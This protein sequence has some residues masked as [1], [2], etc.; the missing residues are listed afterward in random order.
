MK[1]H[2]QLGRRIFRIGLVVVLIGTLAGCNWFANFREEKKGIQLDRLRT[3]AGYKT[4]VLTADI[5]K[6]RQM[7]L[8]NRGTLFV[9]S[10]AG[11]VHAL[12]L[13]ANRVVQARTL[14]MGLNDGSAVAFHNGALFYSDRTRIL[15]MDD[16]ENRLDNPPAPVTVVD[17]LPN[18]ERHGA[19]FM[20][21]GPDNKLY[22]SVGS[23]C[24]LCE[25]PN[26]EFGHVLRVNPDGSGR[27]IFARGIRNTVG[28]D[29]HPQTRD[30]WFTENGQ[31]DLG[32][33][34]PN[35]EL[36]R[37]S[38][39]GEHFGFPYCH[40]TA[41]ADPKFGEKRA[42]SEF[43]PPVFGLGAHV[44]ALGARFYKGDAVAAA[45]RDS[46]IVARHGSH[47]PIRVGYDVVRIKLNGNKVDGMEPFLTGFLQGREYWGR[48]ADVL[49]LPDGSVLVSDD[50]NGAI[51]RV[52]RN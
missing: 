36:N 33:E 9:G 18:E 16:I 31:D 20:M 19:R 27:E 14:A 43:T 50:L 7:V 1:R 17:G 40:D 4:S 42:C 3:A 45:M 10:N 46:M 26:D 8:G 22:I 44:A 13:D 24:N 52:A 28:F 6:A 12:T 29:F 23:P 15:R 38:K 30:L 11:K 48:P 35:D 5:P 32:N 39:V 2:H 41:I 25:A 47:P 34:R 51:Y 49:P 37:V 21:I